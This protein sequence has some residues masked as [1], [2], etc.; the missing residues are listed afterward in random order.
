MIS[1]DAVLA[2]IYSVFKDAY[3]RNKENELRNIEGVDIS[4]KAFIYAEAKIYCTKGG[5]I[6]IGEG[7]HSHGDIHAMLSNSTISVGGNTFIGPG[8]RIW[9]FYKITIGNNVLISH[10]CNVFDNDSHPLDY[11][12]RERQILLQLRDGYISE[13]I[14][15]DGCP[16]N[17]KDN[18]WIGANCTILKGVTIGR[19]AIVGSNSIV[20]KDIPDFAIA[21]GNP[22]RVFRIQESE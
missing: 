8:T 19:G 2:K 7:S 15:V 3:F 14:F 10:N 12:L 9:A 11:Q 21:H 18:A 22:A 16:I 17:I 5:K 1:K 6:S 20:T 13:D 4:R